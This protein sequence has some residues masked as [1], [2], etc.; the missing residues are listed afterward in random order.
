[1]DVLAV[2][3]GPVELEAVRVGVLPGALWLVLA[4]GVFGTLYLR[5]PRLVGVVAPV[6]DRFVEGEESAL[7]P[8]KIVEYCEGVLFILDCVRSP[9][10]ESTVIELEVCATVDMKPVVAEDEDCAADSKTEPAV[11]ECLGCVAVPPRLLLS[12]VS[13]LSLPVLVELPLANEAPAIAMLAEE[14]RVE[15]LAAL[16]DFHFDVLLFAVVPG[17][18]GVK[19][20]LKKGPESV[21]RIGLMEPGSE[22]GSLADMAIEPTRP[23][24]V[25]EFE[26]LPLRVIALEPKRPLGWEVDL[27]LLSGT[28]V[29]P[30][31]MIDE[32]V[33]LVFPKRPPF[34]GVRVDALSKK[35]FEVKSNRLPPVDFFPT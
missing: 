5:A 3:V 27:S 20:N 30:K 6:P 18:G 9:E 31:D 15:D 35:G 12:V 13:E 33:N 8:Q 34:E 25:V 16:G 23:A 32:G 7:S 1:M 11:A 4:V 28:I 10:R 19:L 26:V 29:E 2:S 17:E 24:L 22:S 21:S 14:A